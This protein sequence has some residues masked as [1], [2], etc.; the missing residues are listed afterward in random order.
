MSCNFC[1]GDDAI[2]WKDNANCAF[3]DS[4]GE[5]MVVANDKT[6][7][8]KVKVCPMC[9]HKFEDNSDNELPLSP[10]DD[11]WY[12]DTE[13]EEYLAEHGKIEYITIESGTLIDYASVKFDNGDIDD[14]G[15]N[16]FG[17][18][19]FRTET[20]ARKAWEKAHE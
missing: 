18:Y 8:F 9:G 16:G 13:A 11:I 2:F 14:F 5:M 20:D 6:I 17:N 12:V 10:G 4:K 7:R 1:H 15:P 3:I 19:Y